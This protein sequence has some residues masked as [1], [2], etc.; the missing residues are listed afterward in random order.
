MEQGHFSEALSSL[1]CLIEEYQQ[2]DATKGRLVPDAPRLR[3]AR[4]T[5]NLSVSLYNNYYVIRNNDDVTQPNLL[6]IP[7]NVI[8]QHFLMYDSIQ[9]LCLKEIS[10]SNMTYNIMIRPA[11]LAMSVLLYS[12][13]TTF[14]YFFLYQWFQSFFLMKSGVLVC[15]SF[16]PASLSLNSLEGSISQSNLRSEN[17]S[18]GSLHFLWHTQDVI[19]CIFHCVLVPPLQVKLTLIMRDLLGTQQRLSVQTPQYVGLNFLVLVQPER[20]SFSAFFAWKVG[21]HVFPLG[22]YE[23]EQWLFHWRLW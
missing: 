16:S 20:V 21:R 9:N 23:R 19:H 8:F 11:A 1:S 12:T 14:K 6:Y 15:V 7:L 22:A 13:H 2:L 17:M 5:F 18:P 4:W 3:I 10:S